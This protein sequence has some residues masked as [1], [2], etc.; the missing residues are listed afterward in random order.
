MPS[1]YSWKIFLFGTLLGWFV[2]AAA[3]Q[4]VSMFFLVLTAF[5]VVPLA[6]ADYHRGV[7]P[8]DVLRVTGRE[9]V[10]AKT[11]GGENGNRT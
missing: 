11:G 3:F 6:Y 7:R 10:P 1:P 9:H 5:L 2:P 4:G 8:F